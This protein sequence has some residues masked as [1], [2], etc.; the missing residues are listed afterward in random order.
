[1]VEQKNAIITGASKGIGL[2][3]ARLLAQNGFGVCICSTSQSGIESVGKKLGKNVLAVGADVADSGQCKELFEKA[4]SRF[5]AINVLVNNAGV[6]L[7]KPLVETTEEEISRVI[8]VNLKGAM[9]CSKYAAQI[10]EKGAIIN[11]SS[12]YGK[13]GGANASA[14]CASK[15]GIIGLTKSLS[16]ELYPRI[17]VFAVC[18]GPVETGMLRK[19]FNYKGKAK[20]PSAI[21]EIILD[22]AQ[23]WEQRDSGVTIDVL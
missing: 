5:G 8:D 7:Y 21:A 13:L 4:A 2:E 9:Y 16:M 3:A 17:K 18:P 14:Y 19:D 10:M 11:I 22:L 6:G 15:F 1:M 12:I 20:P 23:N